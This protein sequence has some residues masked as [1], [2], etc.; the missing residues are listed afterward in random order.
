MGEID[1]AKVN[2]TIDD[3]RAINALE[4][5]AFV[6]KGWGITFEWKCLLHSEGLLV[7]QV[8]GTKN[9]EKFIWDHAI[10]KGQ[11]SVRPDA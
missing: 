6:E 8:V 4:Q 9:G 5:K 3:L 2:F 7:V 10:P 1:F 11:W